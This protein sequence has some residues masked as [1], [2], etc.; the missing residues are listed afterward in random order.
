[1]IQKLFKN[2]SIKQKLTAII[3][4]IS[5]LALLLSSISFMVFD[6]IQLKKKMARD[7]QILAD[8]IGNNC[9]AALLF[10]IPRDAQETLSAIRAHQH[11]LAASIYD[12]NNNLF[13]HY[14]RAGTDSVFLNQ[15]MHEPQVSEAFLQMTSLRKNP[16]TQNSPEAIHVFYKDNLLLFQS[17]VFE[18]EFIGSVYLHSDM[19]EIKSRLQGYMGIVAIVILASFMVIYFL[20]ANFQRVVSNPILLLTQTAKKVSSEKDYSIRAIKDSEDEIGFL[21]DSFNEMLSKIEI[22]D[23]ALKHISKELQ[24]QTEQLKKEL[25]ERK[26]AEN[27]IKKSLDEKE[28]LLQEIHHRVKNNLQ[29]ISSLLKL[30][31]KD[32]S[33]ASILTL[34]Q[35]CHNR[36]KTMG[37]IHEQLYQ[38]HDL[39][40]INFEDYVRSLTSYLF[41]IYRQKAANIIIHIDVQ[42]TSF[43]IDLAI[44]CGL[45]INEV[46]SNS[47]KYAFPDNHQGKIDI[48]L[49]N[50]SGKNGKMQS[51]YKY[52]LV[53][54]DN[55]NGLP[56]NINFRTADTLGLKLINALTNQ[57]HGNI[58]LSRKSGTAFT[59]LF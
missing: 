4:L 53:I 28:I 27:K 36:V 59:I 34:F 19:K 48:I 23:N 44:P 30:Q 47:L 20:T 16:N 5:T 25:K 12:S 58:T 21:I 32:I 42:N 33:D 57:L 35:D 8:I 26:K 11:I 51:E 31:F 6:Q 46:I 40:N 17:I 9:S 38:S 50:T 10:N 39:S 43:G 29:I 24:K 14:Q 3:L 2:I 52:K 55:G 41:Q 13:A 15:I 45:I 49:S 18:N 37:L 7:L 54:R 56:K 22:S 1:M